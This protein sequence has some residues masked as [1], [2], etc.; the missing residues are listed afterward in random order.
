MNLNINNDKPTV[1]INPL[2]QPTI[3]CKCGNI[4]WQQG[5]ILKKVSGFLVG[6]GSDDQ[7]ID[8]PVYYCAKCGEILEEYKQ[9]YKLDGQEP[10]KPKSSIITDI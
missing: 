4:V 9:M 10:P 1:R 3:A 5:L 7:I 2:E 6:T 8:L